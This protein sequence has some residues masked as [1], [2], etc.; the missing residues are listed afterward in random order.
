MTKLDWFKAF[1]LSRPPE[2]DDFLLMSIL[3]RKGG[4]ERFRGSAVMAVAACFYLACSGW[5]AEPKLE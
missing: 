3:R 5:S 1:S 2:L 4:D